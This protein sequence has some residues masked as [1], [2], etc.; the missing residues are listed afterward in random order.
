MLNLIESF[1]TLVNT[2]VLLIVV[3]LFAAT[4]FHQIIELFKK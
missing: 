1:G 2:I 4:I 3:V